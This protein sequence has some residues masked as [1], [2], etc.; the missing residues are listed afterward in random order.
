MW[1]AMGAS[2]VA[3]SEGG[4]NHAKGASGAAASAYGGG[5]IDYGCVLAQLN[6]DA[7]AVTGPEL[8]AHVSMSATAAYTVASGP[9]ATPPV[10]AETTA[11]S[12]TTRAGDET[13]LRKVGSLARPAAAATPEATTV[14]LTTAAQAGATAFGNAAC[15][16]AVALDERFDALVSSRRAAIS[17]SS[18]DFH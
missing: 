10:S 13:L 12:T 16:S 18:V 6:L 9:L 14:V 4:I 8:A 15:F 11:T 7:S 1:R 2:G 3:F 5:G 17:M